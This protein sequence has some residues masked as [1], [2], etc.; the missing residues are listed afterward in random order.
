MLTRARVRIFTAIADVT[1][2]H[3]WLILGAAL[4]LTLVGLFLARDLEM[5]NDITEYLPQGSPVVQDFKTALELFGT[6]DQLLVVI[7]GAGAPDTE[8]REALADAMG[9]RLAA[10]DKIRAV[11][12]R[13]TEELA[14]FYRDTFLRYGLLYLDQRERSNLIDLVSDRRIPRQ[15]AEDREVLLSPGVGFSRQ[16]IQWDP[17]NLRSLFL[18]RLERGRGQL[19]ISYQDGYFFSEDLT[20]LVLVVRPV[21]TAKDISFTRDLLADVHR[22]EAEARHEVAENGYPEV[23]DVTV[24]YTGG[25]VIAL[26][27]NELIRKDLVWNILVAF[28]GVMIIFV[29]AFRRVGALFYVGAPLAMALIWNLGLVRLVYGHLNM[30]IG[31]T[32]VVLLGLGIDF[33]IHIMNRFLAERETNADIGDAIRVTVVETGD[34]AVLACGTTMLAFY[35]GLLTDFPGL[36]QLGFIAGTGLLFALLANFFVLPAFLVVYSRMGRHRSRE[37]TGLGLEPLAG[38]VGRHPGAILAVAGAVTVFCGA[39]AFQSSIDNDLARFRPVNSE[40]FRLQRLLVERIGSTFNATM[41][42]SHAPDEEDALDRS[43]RI[44]EELERFKARGLVAS[45]L[46]VNDILPAP[47]RQ[48]ANLEW[49][50]TVREEN[51]SALDPDRV[52]A[53][54]RSEIERQGFDPAAFEEA[55]EG[56]RSFLSV[57]SIL[58]P[59]ELAG[60]AIGLHA[61]RFLRKADGRVYVATYAYSPHGPGAAQRGVDQILSRR[62]EELDGNVRV[63][64]NSILANEFKELIGKDALIATSV[65]LVLILA[66]LYLQFR[67]FRLMLLTSVPLLLGVTWAFGLMT[68][69]G[70]RFSLISVSILPVVLGIGIDDGIY[71]VNRYRF[72]GDRDVVHAFH[73]TGRA[74]VTTSLTTMVGFGS[75]ALADYPGLVGAGLFAFVGI[76]ACLVSAVTVLPA[77]MELFGRSVIESKDLTVSLASEAGGEREAL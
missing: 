62:L 9:K 54:L 71:I 21:K 52:T 3:P 68:L 44:V 27:Y 39:A 36:Q 74:V 65:T 61:D 53:T 17:L 37:M 13:L 5:V 30:F 14:E 38:F 56:I 28:L 75:M 35:A 66:F 45:V 40:P 18:R 51:P 26:E 7:Q 47:A 19:K 34:G 2:R 33:A 76:G 70:Y 63:I 41:I 50:A 58:T 1:Y 25:Y 46:S 6:S 49:L 77:L 64:S 42:L 15:V 22:F 60:T 73:D 72:L 59:E 67:S 12:Y 16:L 48:E 31:V 29:I 23:D 55:F 69:A 11:E 8:V 32:A 24:G 57:N 43:E 10:S 20:L 4:L